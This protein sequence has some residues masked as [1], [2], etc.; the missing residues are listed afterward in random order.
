[1]PEAVTTNAGAFAP[2]ARGTVS[3]N[4]EALCLRSL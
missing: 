2:P 3:S 4:E 1:M